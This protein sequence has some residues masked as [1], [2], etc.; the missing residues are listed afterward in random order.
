MGTSLPEYYYEPIAEAFGPP[1]LKVVKG[2]DVVD[3]VLYGAAASGY[4]F[5]STVIFTY[6]FNFMKQTLKKKYLEYILVRNSRI[7]CLF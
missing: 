6:L 7:R 2:E 4:Y 1:S 3:P 5:D